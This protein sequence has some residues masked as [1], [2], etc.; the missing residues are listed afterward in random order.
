MGS[1][2]P[3][4]PPRLL[5]P[6]PQPP[7]GHVG[8]VLGQMALPAAGA[9]DAGVRWAGACA[10]ARD[11]TGQPA[12]GWAQWG[13]RRGG[14]FFLPSPRRPHTPRDDVPDRPRRDCH[15]KAAASLLREG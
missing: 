8:T 2:H 6:R 3:S 10:P 13:R 11:T 7:A 4:L 14:L 15:G 1:P 5:L 12:P 9:P